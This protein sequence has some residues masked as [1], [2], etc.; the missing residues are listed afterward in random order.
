MKTNILSKELKKQGAKWHHDKYHEILLVNGMFPHYILG[1]FEVEINRTPQ[2]IMN[3]YLYEVLKQNEQFDYVN[4]LAI[5]QE[6]FF[7]YAKSLGY[8][9]YFMAKENKVSTATIG[10]T[11]PQDVTKP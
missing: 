7:E 5:N 4:G 1:I 6:N 10:G 8:K 9:N 11:N 3:P 2:F